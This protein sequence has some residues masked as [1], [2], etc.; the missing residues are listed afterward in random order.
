MGVWLEGARKEGGGRRCGAAPRG[1]RCGMRGCRGRRGPAP[2]NEGNACEAGGGTTPKPHLGG[3]VAARAQLGDRLGAGG[4]RRRH[5]ESHRPAQANREP[6]SVTLLAGPARLGIASMSSGSAH[7]SLAT[8]DICGPS[9]AVG[10]TKQG[11]PG[12]GCFAAQRVGYARTPCPASAA[13]SAT[14]CTR[15]RACMGSPTRN[16]PTLPG[17]PGECYTVVVCDAVCL[18]LRCVC[19]AGTHRHLP[20][21]R[22]PSL[23]P[24]DPGRPRA[25]RATR[26]GQLAVTARWG[27]HVWMWEHTA[28]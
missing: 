18:R 10:I 6:A 11:A 12:P 2:D 15:L 19:H 28:V 17:G 14:A 5:C 3:V 25:V 7:P 22:A 24:G 20:R 4:R 27:S 1:Q 23:S 13:S 16:D 8:Y 26:L 9:P 21:P